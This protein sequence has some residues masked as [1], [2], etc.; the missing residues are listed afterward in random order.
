MN[1]NILIF[2]V[3]ISGK[4]LYSNLLYYPVYNSHFYTPHHLCLGGGA[5]Y[6][7]VHVKKLFY[8]DATGAGTLGQG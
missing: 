1:Q 7:R 4:T 3:R 5:Y 2:H 8:F 6:Q